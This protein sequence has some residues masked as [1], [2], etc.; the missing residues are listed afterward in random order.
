M[1]VVKDFNKAAKWYDQAAAQGYVKARK[2]LDIVKSG[3]TRII[4]EKKDTADQI[5]DAEVT[6]PAE[7]KEKEKTKQFQDDEVKYITDEDAEKRKEAEQPKLKTKDKYITAAE[8]G[9]PESQNFLGWLYLTG[10]DGYEIDAEE[11]AYWFSL[12]AE[13]GNVDAQN[14]LGLL[15]LNGEGIERDPQKAKFWLEKAAESGNVDAQNNLGLLYSEA[16]DYLQAVL[17]FSRA[18]RLGLPEAQYNLAVMYLKG[19]GVKQNKEQ[20]IHWMQKAAS[21]GY[22]IAIMTLDTLMKNYTETTPQ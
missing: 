14:N 13:N 22:L 9:D 4:Q 18:A 1:G 12:A 2:Q 6:L 19:L 20:A 11:A 10:E 5:K 8:M 3:L 15:Y 16:E 21:Q 7:T 17:W